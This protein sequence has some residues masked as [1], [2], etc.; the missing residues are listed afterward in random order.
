MVNVPEKTEV[1]A[2]SEDIVLVRSQSSSRVWMKLGC[3]KGYEQ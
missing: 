1:G 2:V 3:G